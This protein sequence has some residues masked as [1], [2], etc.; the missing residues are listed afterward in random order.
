MGQKND[1]FFYVPLIL[2]N[3]CLV[4]IEWLLNNDFSLSLA[5]QNVKES[6]N[7]M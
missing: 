5:Y 3:F 6:R 2:P 4:I 1:F 7:P